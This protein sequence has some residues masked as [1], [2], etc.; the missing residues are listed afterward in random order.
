LQLF[1]E[2]FVILRTNVTTMY[3]YE[4]RNWPSLT[5]HAEALMEELTHVAH[6]LGMQEGTMRLLGFKEYESALLDS[7]T[8]DV[9]KSSEIEGEALNTEQV[10]SSIARRLGYSMTGL[11]PS[12]RNVDAVVEMMLDATHHCHEPLTKERLCAW[13]ASLFPTGYSGM[14]K[15]EVGK[16]RTTEMQVVSGAMG[17]ERVHYVTPPPKLVE[18]NMETFLNWINSDDA[19]G[20]NPVICAAKAHWWFIMIHPFDDGNG[21]IARAICDLAL[22]RASSVSDGMQGRPYSLAAQILLEKKRYYDILERDG[23]GEGDI[24]EWIL[25][26]ATCLEHAIMSTTD[27][28]QS[29]VRKARFWREH[30]DTQ[31]NERQRKMLNHIFDGI[32][33]KLNSSKWAKMCHCSQDTSLNDIKA[34]MALDILEDTGEGGRSTNYVLTRKYLI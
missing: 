17:H 33:G 25:W 24:T 14:Y 13:Q 29:A 26:F 32:E 3:V 2:L 12:S 34:L 20:M 31:F 15:I 30:A 8:S 6:L 18:Q 22:S 1:A 21:R 19:K 4:R 5:Y 10:R 16:Y 9:V 11:V 23:F 7:M 28:V 27:I